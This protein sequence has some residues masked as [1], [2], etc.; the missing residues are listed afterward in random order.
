MFS[1]PYTFRAAPGQARHPDV[2]MAAFAPQLGRI[3]TR[4]VLR[5]SP[6]G[7]LGLFAQCD[8]PAGEMVHIEKPLLAV[9]VGKDRCYHCTGLL[10]DAATA[11]ACGGCD[12]RYCRQACH[13]E[14]LEL[15]HRPLC[16]A[17]DGQ[18]VASLETK[19][20]EGVSASSL[21][22]L[23][24]WKMLGWALTERNKAGMDAALVRPTDMPPFCHF[25]RRTDTLSP[26]EPM[27][28]LSKPIMMLWGLVRELLPPALLSE[29]ALSV[30]WMIDCS[31]ML[32][33][34]TIGLYDNEGALGPQAL[35]YSASFFNHS[36]VPN[37]AD[38]AVGPNG[39]IAFMAERD[40]AAG[41]ELFISY[42]AVSDAREL[43]QERLSLQYG[44][45][46]RCD[47]CGTETAAE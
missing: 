44:F 41:D 22:L 26:T 39:I 12:R 46:C 27:Y 34:N 31:V 11:V 43:R 15:Y 32:M 7:G 6:S 19:A 40:I 25:L 5:P 37:V 33:V 47:R 1:V 45:A 30:Q 18:A 20:G 9:A 17:A 36:C 42:A 28:F 2:V 4:A 38:H 13:D 21:N 8:I 35:M 23:Y 10:Q 24:M 14:A 29:P 3:V 16:G